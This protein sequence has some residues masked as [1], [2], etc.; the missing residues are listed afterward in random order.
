[1]LPYI[2]FLFLSN[3]NASKFWIGFRQPS[4]CINIVCMEMKIL[5]I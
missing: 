4:D 5:N 1:M 3:D 2:K